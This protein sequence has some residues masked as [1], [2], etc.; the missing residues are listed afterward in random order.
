MHAFTFSLDFYGNN[1]KFLLY[2]PHYCR[3]QATEC[4]CISCLHVRLKPVC[5]S[6]VTLMCCQQVFIVYLLAHRAFRNAAVIVPAFMLALACC[7][8]QSAHEYSS[9]RI[10]LALHL[11]Y[12]FACGSTI[13][14]HIFLRSRHTFPVKLHTVYLAWCIWK[15]VIVNCLLLPLYPLQWFY[16]LCG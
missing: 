13:T 12:S 5:L 3:H 4:T 15:C 6:A 9:A 10:Y 8:L 1:L 16:F 11:L 7:L 2:M 14:P